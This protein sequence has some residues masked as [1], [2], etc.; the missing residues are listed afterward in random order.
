MNKQLLLHSVRKGV[1]IFILFI[2]VSINIVPVGTSP[3]FAQGHNPSFNVWNLEQ[4]HGYDWPFEAMVTLTI[5]DTATPESPDYTV[6]QPTAPTD[7]DPSGHSVRFEVSPN[8]T[9]QKGHIV[10]LSSG[11]YVK[12]HTIV[13]LNVTGIN[14]DSDTVTGTAAPGTLIRVENKWDDQIWRNEIAN[15]EGT[16][17]AGF[18]VAGDEPGENIADIL[19][20][21]EYHI[22]KNDED[23]DGTWFHMRVPN[24]SIQAQLG[25]NHVGGWEWP[26][27]ETVTVEIDDPNTGQNPDLTDTAVV[28]PNEWEGTWFE[29][30]FQGLYDLKGGDLVTVSHGTTVKTLTVAPLVI[31]NVDPDLDTVSGTTTPGAELNVWIHEENSPSLDIAA[32][33]VTGEWTADFA[34]LWDIGF[35]SDGAAGQYDEDGD[36]TWVGWEVDKPRMEVSYEHDWVQIRGFTPGGDVTYTIYDGEGGH[37]LFGPVTGPVDSHG[38]GWI[39]QQLT[40]TDLIPGYF[41]TAVNETTGEEVSLLIRDLNFDYL[42]VDDDRAFGTAEPNT[43]IDFHVSE[44]YQHGFNL[45]VDVDVSGYWEIDLAAAGYPIESYRHAGVDLYD[46]EGDKVHAQAPRIVAQVGTDNVGIDFYTKNDDITLTVYDSPG[47]SILYGPEILRTD[48]AGKTW[49]SLWEHGIDLVPGNYVEAY[50]HF[51]GF[52]KSL[53][54]EDFTFD[55]IDAANDNV[56]GTSIPGEWVELHVESL[57]SNWHM[58]VLTDENGDWFG[59]YGVQDYDITD[60]M[61][62][63]G[64][65]IDDQNN[66]SEDHITGLPNIE[67]SVVDDWISGYNFSP[68]RNVRIQI[69]D[70]EGGNLLQEFLDYAQGD[71]QFQADHQ[72]HGIDLQPGMYL[73]VEDLETGKI[74]D[75]LLQNLTFEGVDYDTDTAWGQAGPGAQ[76][77]VRANHIF[78]SYE[79][80]VIAE[81]PSGDWFADFGALGADLTTDW[82]L[83]A[84]IFD[85]ENDATV[86]DVPQP[87]E[88]TASLDMNWVNGDHWMPDNNVEI[89]VFEFE[90]G[91]Q[92]GVPV[93]WNTD[94]YGHFNANLWNEGFDL[95][96]GYY[97]TVNDNSSGLSKSLTLANLSIDYFDPDNDVAGGTAPPDTRISVDFNNDQESIQFDLF[98]DSNGNWEA[99]FGV[100]DFDL[101]PDSGGSVRIL[102][103]DGDATQVEVISCNPTFRIN[104][105]LWEVEVWEW[106]LDVAVTLNIDDPSNGPGVDYTD[107]QYAFVPEWDPNS[108]Y[109]RFDFR[110]VFD[111]LPGFIVTL[112]DGSITKEHIVTNHTVTSVDPSNDQVTGTAEPGSELVAEICVE[113]GCTAVDVTTDQ[114]GDWIAGFTGLYDIVPGTDGA[115]HQFDEDGDGTGIHWNVPN[116]TIQVRAN[117]DRVEG[118]EW[119][120][121][122]TVAVDVDNPITPQNPDQTGTATVSVAPWDPNQTYFEL[123]FGEMIDI[124]PG[125]VVTATDGTSTKDHIVT[126]MAITDF[127]LDAEIVYGVATPNVQIDAWVCDDNGCYNNNEIPVDNAGNWSANFQGIYDIQV[128]TW[129]DSIEREEDGDGTM[130][131]V[132]IPNPTI[133]TKA[134]TDVVAGMEWTEGETVTIHIDDPSTPENPDCTDYAPVGLAPWNPDQTYFELDLAEVIDIQPGFVVTATDGATTKDH[135][136]TNLTITDFDLDGDIVYGVATPNGEVDVWICDDNGCTNAEGIP[137]DV[138]GN[139]SANFQGVYNLEVGTRVSSVETD[140]DG[141]GTVYGIN[142]PSENHSPYNLTIYAPLDPVQIGTPVNV[143]ATFEDPDADDIHTAV[144]DWGDNTSSP[145]TVNGYDITGENVYNLPGVYTLTL[146]IIDNKGGEATA[147]YQFIVTYDPEGGFVT[148]GGWIW[149]PVGAYAADP[150]LTGKA[151][152]GFVSKYKKGANVPTGNTNFQFKTGDLHFESTSYD[153]LV[154]AGHDKAKYKG[155][156]TINGSGNYG[157]ML[158]AIDG[159]PDTFRIK[160]WDKDDGDVVVYDNKMGDSD[161]SYDGTALGGGNIKVHNK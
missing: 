34:G 64:W 146:T 76:V 104:P 72:E 147:Y 57:F 120:E 38:E 69:F 71:T 107:T 145:G 155:V 118:Q 23:G 86:A 112:S 80:T 132:L 87:P 153:W 149:S 68:D 49:V 6:T 16:W 156:G 22:G 3:V 31:T 119:P 46:A 74:S 129:V 97:I 133:Q 83:R 160:I 100:H 62:A 28:K 9:M 18:G 130:Y 123:D 95:Q 1:N 26:L 93:V 20:G 55:G 43:T 111:A 65:A 59:D 50:D 77:V 11:F 109:I 136:V 135:V 157:F 53:E 79:V 70:S 56:F 134:N 35:N 32:D 5:E 154:I 61:W 27:G 15:T 94:N 159:S 52:T 98:S 51:L 113:S 63:Y 140:E 17:L 12:S 89:N 128:G 84:H 4:V 99:D 106:P 108:T 7:W 143:S 29:V 19:P 152:F 37:T 92:V 42:G 126:N 138:S 150:S 96:P 141:D 40:H 48:G 44:T 102:D 33:A 142:I 103:E 41:I 58:N 39:S 115:V 60:Q 82:D 121:G 78:D 67:A 110:D 54:V 124:Q 122:A 45:S 10:T 144:W 8:F 2:L 88:F 21:E 158:S 151:N 30:D 13:E 131:G 114:N 14:S 161:D 116:P 148:G 139:W 66:W 125:F 47:G 85:L 105:D 127:D 101:Q 81:D 117:D 91:S 25:S 137:V 36:E 73:I 75:L 24:P 90:G